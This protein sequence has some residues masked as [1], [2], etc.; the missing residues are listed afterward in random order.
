MSNWS[1]TLA[2]ILGIPFTIAVA[3]GVWWLLENGWIALAIAI[4]T[5]LLI[6]GAVLEIIHKHIH[7]KGYNLGWDEASEY[8]ANKKIV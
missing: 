4:L 3:W 8:Y 5:P 6:V 1:E 2:T 7:R